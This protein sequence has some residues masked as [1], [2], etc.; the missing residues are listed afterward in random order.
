MDNLDPSLIL[1]ATNG[2]KYEPFEAAQMRTA[3]VA[4]ANQNLASEALG[5]QIGAQDLQLKQYVNQETATQLQEQQVILKAVDAEN[6][7]VSAANSAAPAAVAP[8]GPAG[9]APAAAPLAPVADGSGLIDRTGTAATPAAAPSP[10]PAAVPPTPA[11]FNWDNVTNAIRVQVR[12]NTSIVMQAQILGSKQKMADFAKTQGEIQAAQEKLNDDKN[13]EASQQALLVQKNGYSLPSITVMAQHLALAGHADVANQLMQLVG[14]NPDNVK[15]IID[16]I[17]AGS[18]ATMQTAQA[19]A[20][21]AASGA[22]KQADEAPA[23]ASAAEQA[24]RTQMAAN[25]L[26]APDAGTYNNMVAGLPS[27]QRAIVPDF[28]DPDRESKLQNIGLTVEQRAANALKAQEIAKLNTPT[29]LAA[30]ASDPTKTAAERQMAND[31]LKRMNQYQQAGRPV[32]Q[33]VNLSPEAMEMYADALRNGKPLPTFGRNGGTAIANI[34]N[35]AAS[36]GPVDMAASAAN[37]KADQGSLVATTKML[38]NVESFEG[39]AGKN[40]QQFLDL[41]KNIPDTGVP[42]LNTPVRLLSDKMVGSTNMAAVNAARD[43]A[44]REI[45]RITADPKMSGVLS[46]SARH[47]V[48]NLSPTDATL[49]QIRTVASVVMN[50]VK[51]VHDN[52]AR[53]KAAIQGRIGN[54]PSAQNG[55]VENSS[56]PTG[57]GKAADAGVIKQFLDASGG[58]K[59]KARQALGASGWTIPAK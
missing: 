42:W 49:A 25:L 33:N 22:D 57:G 53:Q 30:I 52:V 27:G 15:P 38:D 45:A 24:Q 26:T 28:D 1:A 14:Q 40:L 16:A 21:T 3:Q 13:D 2:P 36:K 37:Y 6:A 55:A 43:V 10:A 29:E 58:D 44:L 50:D 31:A 11:A 9:S 5:M 47:E 39:A 59:V 48:Q 17:A 20:V 41:A 19:R 18:T 56:L 12:P 23:Q 4:Q 34:S 46:D 8:A 32:Q 54:G 35:L 7:R 51:N